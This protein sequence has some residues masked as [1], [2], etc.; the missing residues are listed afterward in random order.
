MRQ[1]A[2]RQG[3]RLATIAIA[4]AMV[5]LGC[6][7]AAEAPPDVAMIGLSLTSLGP[8]D[9]VP[10]TVLRV[11][12]DAFVEAPWGE[13]NL[14][15]TLAG[16]AFTLPAAYVSETAV[17]VALDAAA[18]AAIGVGAHAGTAHIAVRSTEDGRLYETAA[19]PV[20]LTLSS[21]LTPRLVAVDAAAVE[22][23]NDDLVLHAEGLLL[24][25]AEGTTVALLA[26]CKTPQG[27]GPCVDMPVLE[28]DVVPTSLDARDR[29]T[30]RLGP[31][32]VGLP[33]G[34]WSGEMLLY[35]RHGAG[36]ETASE[37]APLVAAL[38]A[39]AVTQVG[40]AVA[41]LGQY[42]DISGGG[43]LGGR[44]G[45]FSELRLIGT[46]TA[47]A[48]GDP[49]SLIITLVPEFAHG[50]LMR[51]VVNEV[52]ALGSALDLRRA[53]G[54]Y[55]GTARPFVSFDDESLLGD[56]APFSLRLAPVRQ[57]IFLDFTASYREALRAFGLRALPAAVA[58][59]AAA[60]T[61][62]AFPSVGVDVRL[63][64]PTDMAV[65]S[66]V[67]I[68]GP[69][70]NGLGLLGYD[71]SPGKDAYNQRLYDRIGGANAL[72]QQDGAPGYGGVFVDSL[73]AFSLRPAFGASAQG[74]DARFDQIFDALRPDGGRPADATDL[75]AFA[76]RGAGAGCPAATRADQVACAVWVMGSLIGSTLAH[77]IGHSLG[78][79]NPDGAGAHNDGDLPDRLMDGGA[80]RPFLERAEL[81][82]EGPGVFCGDEYAYLRQILPSSLAA[83]P[84]P[85]PAC[86]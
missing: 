25:G 46:Y 65:Y 13:T 41:T 81:A 22:F 85:R 43:F 54:V 86:N 24:G 36:D 8:S 53:A 26:G 39:P 10:G 30:V 9:L 4:G 1:V 71:N 70:P 61:A 82:G 31:E 27:G 28:V 69:D 73:M 21:T 74:A 83:D 67:E 32:L 45:Q 44:P 58:T 55:E 29:G 33:P 23:V 62:A 15:L 11:R 12:G 37:V 50:R 84:S 63:A 56:A 57:V 48:G 60:V 20:A 59:R 14:V 35:N 42:V 40:P 68:M 52:D 49:Q 51:Y 66:H 79:A 2:S 78:L 5:T 34:T 64:V 17:T 47:D 3:A 19:L 76:P 18:F 38:R 16:R 75:A 72:T 80:A 7:A 6:G 77:E